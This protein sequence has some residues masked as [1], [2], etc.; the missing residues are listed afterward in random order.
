MVS[1]KALV[2]G[3]SKPPVEFYRRYETFS[4]NKVGSVIVCLFQIPNISCAKLYK[5]E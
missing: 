3:K 4:L 5:I 2:V 1:A